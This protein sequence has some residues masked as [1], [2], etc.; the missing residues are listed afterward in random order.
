MNN[1]SLV[2]NIII[3]I[4]SVVSVILILL[5]VQLSRIVL[6]RRKRDL[7]VK[8]LYER[9]SMDRLNVYNTE[10]SRVNVLAAANPKYQ[11]I[12]KKLRQYYDKIED[13]YII[14]N[15][16]LSELN[17]PGGE[18]NLKLNKYS[19]SKKEFEF[20][21]NEIRED[22][23]D[24]ELAELNFE[25]ISNEVMHQD[26]YL[27][28]EFSHFRINVRKAISVYQSKR[29]LLDKV[30]TK[31][32]EII[33][34]IKST[35]KEFENLILM[36]KM[37]EASECLRKYS[38][39]AI[40]MA[41][42][43]NEG[44][45]IQMYIDEIIKRAVQAIVEKFNSCK[46]ELA[47]SIH[48]INFND[49]IKSIAKQ[50]EQAKHEYYLL[51]INESKVLIRKILKSIKALEKLINFEIKARKLVLESFKDINSEVRVALQRYLEIK[52]QFRLLVTKVS[53]I[54]LELSDAFVQLRSLSK[55][56][57]SKA[58]NFSQ[59]IADKDIAY[60]SKLERSR[61]LVQ[62]TLEFTNKMN[63]IMQMLWTINIE[64]SLLRNK[65][66][67]AE[68]AIN[69]VLANIK[70]QNIIISKEEKSHLDE[71]I[72]SMTNVATKLTDE[73]ISK[74]VASEIDSM[75]TKSATLYK[76]LSTNIQI[77]EMTANAIREY[78]PQRALD[79]KI[80]FALMQS[81]K[82]YLEGQYPEALNTLLVELESRK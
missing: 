40:K 3:P 30:S 68:A 75:V 21:V 7:V 19:L 59:M 69:E 23:K 43:I 9:V 1:A 49:S 60:S 11:D 29:L 28:S 76:S 10:V 8:Q 34:N 48:I 24:I 31:I 62:Y 47:G 45:Q 5:L 70:R 74:E 81:E 22:I 52:Q 32:D 20:K 14:S 18:E 53:Q 12:A 64:S 13:L 16:I 78:S 55:N 63:E 15:R 77:A 57:D 82:L 44:P 72:Q 4:V 50:F 42:I 37:K 51:H 79:E 67:R 39:L 38:K 27:N 66:K 54:P 25:T 41:E 56:I 46:E 17:H 80:N 36:G 26:E 2:T 61:S 6:K 33:T 58:M 35:E 71:I 65:F 73:N